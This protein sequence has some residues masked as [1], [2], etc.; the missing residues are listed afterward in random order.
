[1]LVLDAQGAPLDYI[2]KPGTAV[3]D[4]MSLDLTAETYTASTARSY[5][6]DHTPTAA[7]S[8]SVQ[9]ALVTA[10][11]PIF[12]LYTSHDLSG[13]PPTAFTQN[14]PAFTGAFDVV[15][16]SELPAAASSSR[17]IVAWGPYAGTFTVDYAANLVADFASFPMFDAGTHQLTWTEA[18]GA[19][20]AQ[21]SIANLYV[22][23]PT[24][25]NAWRWTIV[26]PHVS[27]TIAYPVLPT[28]LYD[29]N[30]AAT[31]NVTIEDV[32]IAN[33]PGGY[34]TVRP[35]VLSFYGDTS[36]GLFHLVNPT[37]GVAAY[38]DAQQVL[39]TGHH[40]RARRR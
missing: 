35:D 36:L 11:G 4:Q 33:V 26:A 8:L 24:P 32:L 12:R 38:S 25:A 17:N 1:V 23:R 10:R 21:L 2:W 9:D 6:L 40:R 28:D 20:G 14:M 22:S 15:A 13:G 3:A 30:V 39:F 7:S 29:Y 5:T 19:I 34:N 27:A 37:P 16:T 31:D 18:G